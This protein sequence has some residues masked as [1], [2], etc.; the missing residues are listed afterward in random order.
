MTGS[1]IT[2]K[3]SLTGNQEMERK[4]R[5]G[6]STGLCLVYQKGKGGDIVIVRY[7]I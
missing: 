1:L 6:G 5:L 7:I 4:I 3:P 2:W